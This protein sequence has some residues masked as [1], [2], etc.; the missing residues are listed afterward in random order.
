MVYINS[1]NKRIFPNYI[2]PL[3]RELFTSWLCRMSTAHDIKPLSFIQNY[4]GRNQ[5]ILTRDIDL[6]AP[7]YIIN[8]K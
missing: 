4:F 8:L 3:P 1:I 2:K 6:F 7:D 5:P